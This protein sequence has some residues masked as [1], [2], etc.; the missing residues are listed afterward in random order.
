VQWLN[1]Y[2]RQFVSVIPE[3]LL[4]R[5]EIIE[6]CDKHIALNPGSTCTGG[7]RMWKSGGPSVQHAG[8]A[9]RMLAVISA[10]EL[11]DLRLPGCSV[12]DAKTKHRC[13]GA[14]RHE[15]DPFG[16]RRESADAFG[17]F[18]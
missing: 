9:D 13:L 7:I 2:C 4:R 15:A 14:R 12:C 5:R 16:A 18:D 8:N 3:Y 6:G 17:E 1:D 10:F 11:Q